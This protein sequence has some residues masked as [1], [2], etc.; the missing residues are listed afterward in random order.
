METDTD[1]D[2]LKEW[3]TNVDLVILKA[4]QSRCPGFYLNCVKD[5][6]RLHSEIIHDKSECLYL[7]NIPLV[8][9]YPLAFIPT[10][11][12][13]LFSQRYVVHSEPKETIKCDPSE[14]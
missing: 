12:Q 4:L 8:T 1:Y 10:E 11:N 7:D 5:Q 13:F 3:H 9:F 2:L 14:F 6:D